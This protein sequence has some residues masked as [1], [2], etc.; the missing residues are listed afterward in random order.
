VSI[1][2]IVHT[3]IEEVNRSKQV[4]IKTWEQCRVGG[5]VIIQELCREIA[6]ADLFCADLTGMNANVMFELG[7][8]IAK[9]KRIWLVL[10][11]SFVDSRS[12]FEQLRILTTVGYATYCNSQDLRTQFFKDRPHTDLADTIF[13]QTVEPSLSSTGRPILL[14]L[15]SR[16]ENEAS[17]RISR[18]LQ[19]CP[20]PLIS[21]AGGRSAGMLPA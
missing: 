14:H 20:I 18:G 13:R 21:Y 9:N 12:H 16:H 4:F 19:K 7:Y 5:K 10:D 1:G 3:A 2:E 6:T 8:A 11:T 17:I 15:K